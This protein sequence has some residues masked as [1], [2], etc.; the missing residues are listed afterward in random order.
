LW[1]GLVSSSATASAISATTAATAAAPPSSTAAEATSPT[2]A[3]TFGFGTSFVNVEGSA[4]NLF[5]IDGVDRALAFRVVR[6][7]DECEPSGLA[8]IAI[9]DNVDT[10]NAAVRFKQRTDILLSCAET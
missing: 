2:P 10:I 6:H 1:G 7:F 8:G 4:A 3:A 5:A 9:R